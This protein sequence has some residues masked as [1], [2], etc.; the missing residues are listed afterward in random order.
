MR[1]VQEDD[2]E[3]D[4]GSCGTMKPFVAFGRSVISTE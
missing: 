4:F 3:V 1:V 2:D